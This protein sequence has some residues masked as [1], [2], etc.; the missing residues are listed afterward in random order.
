M[1]T[2]QKKVTEFYNIRY[3]SLVDYSFR[4][5][6]NTA[7]IMNTLTLNKSMR[8]DLISMNELTL[9]HERPRAHVRLQV[10]AYEGKCAVYIVTLYIRYGF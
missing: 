2:Y 8:F 1:Y 6:L 5:I 3:N 9:F 10:C 4:E 7:G